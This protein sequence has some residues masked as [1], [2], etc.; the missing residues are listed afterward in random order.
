LIWCIFAVCFGRESVS[1]EHGRRDHCSETTSGF[2][3]GPKSRDMDQGAQLVCRRSSLTLI[4]SNKMRLVSVESTPSLL[5]K[6]TRN[7]HAVA[8]SPFALRTSRNVFRHLTVDSVHLSSD[9][10]RARYPRLRYTRHVPSPLCH[11]DGG[12]LLKR[13]ENGD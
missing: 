9:M 1:R 8:S 3:H 10:P 5:T 6:T 11:E 13:G 12:E 2:L 7:G 4:G